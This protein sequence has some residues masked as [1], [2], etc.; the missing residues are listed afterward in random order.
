MNNIFFGTDLD[1]AQVYRWLLAF[2]GMQLFEDYSRPDQQSRWFET[3]EAAESTSDLVPWNLA[4]WSEN[5]GGRPRIQ[6]IN[7]NQNTQRKL[8]AR[9]RMA[10]HSPAT[11]KLGRDNDQNGCLANSSI[12][13]WTEKGARQRS[14]YPDEFLDEVDWPQLR[15]TVGKV[16][17]Q[18]AKSAPAKMR[19]YAIMPDAYEQL[20]AG[21][22]NL[23]NEGSECTFDSPLITVK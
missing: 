5:I 9:G 16:Q 15:S 6:N 14:I 3:W 19:A 18:I 8:G 22:I 17:R 13:C 11:I 21:R 20:R 7:F 10:L 2:Q 12:S 1:H 23:W 4:A